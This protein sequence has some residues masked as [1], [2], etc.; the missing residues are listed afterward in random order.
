[1]KLYL[2]QIDR[3]APFKTT[4]PCAPNRKQMTPSDN[5]HARRQLKYRRIETEVRRLID[6]LPQDSKMPTERELAERFGCS[7]LTVRKGLQALVD[8]GSIRRVMGSGT[9][10]NRNASDNPTSQETVGVLVWQPSGDFAY[11]VLQSIADESIAQDLRIRSEWITDF[12]DRAV[13]QVETLRRQGCLAFTIPW[14]PHELT[15]AVCS[16]VQKI[17]APISLPELVP[18][19]EDHCF[20]S[21]EVFGKQSYR[22]IELLCHYFAA[23]KDNQVIAFLGPDESS[24]LILQQ[25][26]VA[27]TSTMSRL[28]QTMACN[29]VKPNR[30][31]M[32]KL[33][34]RW[35]SHKGKL[36]VVSY[37]DEHALRLITSMH[38]I[39]LRAPEDFR[40]VGYNNSPA[41]QFSDPP[42]STVAQNYGHIA[43]WL[44][45]SALGLANQS[46]T[47]AQAVPDCPLVVRE[48]CGNPL[49]GSEPIP[50]LRSV[51]D[52]EDALDANSRS[53]AEAR[54]S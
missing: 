44:L 50:G 8:E 24:N 5:A 51:H 21:P 12:G 7:V 54:A 19:F 20:E 43:H 18:G 2:R 13:A 39:G 52:T 28:Q 16:F 11:R 17:D 27:Y 26:L 49:E 32:D 3:R 23:S 1:M 30:H 34:E 38:K 36:A 46:P 48:S 4:Q 35:A 40:I 45:R 42:L 37:D 15:E 22:I 31:A 33:A 10:V 41:S 9:F 6:S 14:F 47:Q 53:D 25:Q 29:L